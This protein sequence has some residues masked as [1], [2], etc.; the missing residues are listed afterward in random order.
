MYIN[1]RMEHI[2]KGR[3]A[4]KTALVFFQTKGWKKVA[5]NKRLAG[6]EID[7][8]LEKP[9]AY[10]LVEVKSDNKWRRERPLSPTQKKRLLKAFT[11]FCER[12]KKPVQVQLAIVDKNKKV[13]PFDLEF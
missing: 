7:L 6:V 2:K 8:I 11:C 1:T 3:L 9:E 5:K 13:Y 10:L 12:H 4:E